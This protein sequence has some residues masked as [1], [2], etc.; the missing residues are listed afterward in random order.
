MRPFTRADRNAIKTAFRMA[1]EDIGT[2]AQVADIT[3]VN[4]TRLS[5]YGNREHSDFPPID[6]AMDVDAAS[7]GHRILK[8]FAAALGC[9]VVAKDDPRVAVECP[10]QDA[11][12]IMKEA[13][14]A[15]SALAEV[16]KRPCPNNAKQ[17]E[18]ELIELG[19]VVELAEANAR[20]I[21]ARGG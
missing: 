15:M 14:E 17:A 5:N 20:R 8:A 2:L 21:Q 12:A 1:C 7:G 16:V 13:G 10:M 11:A 9:D 19:D 6:I 3:R 4:I 18:R